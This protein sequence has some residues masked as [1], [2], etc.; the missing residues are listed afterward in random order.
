MFDKLKKKYSKISGVFTSV[1]T[2]EI[3]NQLRKDVQQMEY[4]TIGIRFGGKSL[5][6]REAAEFLY[7]QLIKEIFLEMKKENTDENN[8]QSFIEMN[9]FC[10]KKYFDNPL[11][12]EKI[13]QLAKDYQSH[14]AIHW[15]REKGFLYRLLNYA[16]SSH[17]TETLYAL[18]YFICQLHEEL[19]ELKSKYLRQ[20]VDT[21]NDLEEPTDQESEDTDEE[22]KLTLFFGYGT[23]NDYFSQ[24]KANRDHLISISTFLSMSN[25]K[26]STM[27][28]AKKHADRTDDNDKHVGIFIQ[29]A[30]NPKISINTP[31]GLIADQKENKD[32]VNDEDK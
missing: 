18:R 5:D 22:D 20:N 13:E 19:N 9:D 12:L 23:T 4:N 14:S 25:S 1:N 26:E 10:R 27:K 28:F 15:Y 17:H 29:V 11:E 24:L 8:K 6:K 30:I 16:L 3:F 21:N 7:S 2:E 31:F 32:E